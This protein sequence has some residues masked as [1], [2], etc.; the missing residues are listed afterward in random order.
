MN[1]TSTTITGTAGTAEVEDARRKPEG[2]IPKAEGSLKP[3]AQ[4]PE[5]GIS[6]QYAES[7]TQNPGPKGRAASQVPKRVFQ[8]ITS[9]VL[10]GV[11]VWYSYRWYDHACTWTRTDNAY[12]A[13]HIHTVSARV[14]GTVKEVLL[15]ENQFVAA[16][17][18]LARLD[19]RDFEVRCQQARALVEQARAQSQQAEAQIAQA[20]AQIAREQARAI[21]AKLDFDRATSLFQGDTGAISRQEFDQAK[22]ES[23][24]AQAALQGAQSTLE[25][26]RALVTAAQA[27]EQAAQASLDDAQLQL[28]YTEIT[29]PSAGRIGKKNLE[30]GNRVQPGQALL[31]LVEP[32]VWVT[33]N[34]KETQLAR[35]KP[36]QPVRIE[37]D[38]LPGQIFS[39]QVESLSP[40]SGAQF[41]LLP[42]D[43]ATGNFTRIVQRV[44]VRIR[45]DPEAFG[46]SENRL[47]P[48][49][50]AVVEVNVRE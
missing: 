24:S 45:F 22:A 42:P 44:P 6:I 9:L 18:V 36:G 16:G 19:S 10:T 2:R 17:S 32:E 27:Q 11:A 38:A 1:A 48:G 28:S 34:F 41:A 5:A 50:S 20:K 30:T 39:G 35:M 46:E 49:M 25:S 31:A 4:G 14:A 8:A 7:S 15:E 23:D 40:A 3:E 13:A 47:L 33:A 29:A 21:K 43:N 26:A 37:M 12:V